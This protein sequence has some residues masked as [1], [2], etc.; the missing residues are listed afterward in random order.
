MPR[1]G[2]TTAR[3]YGHDHQAERAR[4]AP[5]VAH[6]VIPCTRCG[7]L[8]APGAYWDLGHDDNDRSRW[9]GPEH[10]R[11]NRAAG[12]RKGNRLRST[13]HAITALRM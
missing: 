5:A 1:N 9:T 4:W 12:A 10:R 2:D 3:G 6:G 13:R 7:H 11:C 8:I